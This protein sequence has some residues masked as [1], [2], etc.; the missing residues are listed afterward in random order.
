MAVLLSVSTKFSVGM[1]PDVCGLIWFKFGT[2]VDSFKVCTL[3]LSLIDLDLHSRSLECKK[4]TSYAP[5]ITQRFQTI[6][7]GLVCC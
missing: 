7:I 3:I 5:I 1:H 4:A 2:I 6:W